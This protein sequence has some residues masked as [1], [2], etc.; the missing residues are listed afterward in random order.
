MQDTTWEKHGA[1][2]SRS[3][4]ILDTVSPS[5]NPSVTKHAVMSSHILASRSKLRPAAK[6]LP[7]VQEGR[8][9]QCAVAVP[10]A[11]MAAV[12]VNVSILLPWPPPHGS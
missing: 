6:T 2:Q 3:F 5:S 1:P 4:P 8:R 9:G 11:S 10:G 7:T 12:L